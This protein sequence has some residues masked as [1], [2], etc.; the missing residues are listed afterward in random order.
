MHAFS[1]WGAVSH[2]LEYSR[3]AIAGKFADGGSGIAVVC[4]PVHAFL[5]VAEPHCAQP[6]PQGPPVRDRRAFSDGGGG[7]KNCLWSR[8]ALSAD[9][10]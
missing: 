5:Y 3:W 7:T 9:Q 6:E 4:Q 10:S 8:C 1:A 2:E